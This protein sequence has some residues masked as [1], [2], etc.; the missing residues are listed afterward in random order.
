MYKEDTKEKKI[1]QVLKL[2]D[3]WR[4]KKNPKEA[5]T[6]KLISGKKTTSK[7]KKT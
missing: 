3:S 6:K 5:D 1:Q 7:Y 2:T 4:P